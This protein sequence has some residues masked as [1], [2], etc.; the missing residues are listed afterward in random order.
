MSNIEYCPI[1]IDKPITVFTECNH[2]YC[3]NCLCRIKTCAMCRNL[4]VRSKIC[5]EIKTKYRVRVNM[6]IYIDIGGL[7]YSN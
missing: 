1:C 5:S 2:G 4:L 6:P 7:A 3:I